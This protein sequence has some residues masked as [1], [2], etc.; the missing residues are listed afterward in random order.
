M[1]QEEIDK[2]LEMTKTTDEAM[3]RYILRAVI[4]NYP[5]ESQLVIDAV[6]LKQIGIIN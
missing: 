1:K 2:M 5:K 3:V 4:R 6:I